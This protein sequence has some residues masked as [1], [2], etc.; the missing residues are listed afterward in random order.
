[1]C[2]AKPFSRGDAI[3]A[4]VFFLLGVSTTHFVDELSAT[5]SEMQTKGSLILISISE[6][7]VRKS[8]NIESR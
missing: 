4:M 5:V 6:N 8:W 1:M 2:S 7:T 3:M